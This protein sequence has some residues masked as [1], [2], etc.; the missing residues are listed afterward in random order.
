MIYFKYNF[1]HFTFHQV[2]S[3]WG[4][5]EDLISFPLELNQGNNPVLP[6]WSEGSRLCVHILIVAIRL[7][8]LLEHIYHLCLQFNSLSLLCEGDKLVQTARNDE[9][10]LNSAS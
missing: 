8:F 9:C 10:R 4:L 2:L 5:C 6:S 3:W 7:V 1:Y